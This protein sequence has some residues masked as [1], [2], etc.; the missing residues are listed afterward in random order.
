MI[1]LIA[2]A[3]VRDVSENAAW[4]R[5]PL[6][7]WDLIGRMIDE[8]HSVNPVFSVPW[9]KTSIFKPDWLH[10]VDQGVAADF[11]GSFFWTILPR[12]PGNNREARVASLWT[13][14]QR[15][16]RE[17]GVSDR[18][19]SLT[20]NMIKAPGKS[21]KLRCSAA[22]VRRLVPL[23]PQ[24]AQEVLGLGDPQEAAAR[25]AAEALH[26]CYKTL[27]ADSVDASNTLH[28]QSIKFALAYVA[29]SDHSQDE[30][31]WRVKPK[32]H[33]F[34]HLASDGRRPAAHWCYR[35]EDFGGAV[36]RMC[37]SRGGKND[38][39]TLS[40]R[41]LDLCRVRQPVLRA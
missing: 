6:S 10:A 12:L 21:A 1:V 29:L 41:V 17:S 19:Q 40:T 38:G 9:V 24:L 11:A 32:M 13:R 36:G 28:R 15:Y 34:M 3:Q 16:Y 26:E 23:L 20:P 30:M 5:D 2:T 4:R 31:A 22:Q 7:H 14:V 33:L 27:S 8:G 37:R 39:K 25:T 35:D 18:L